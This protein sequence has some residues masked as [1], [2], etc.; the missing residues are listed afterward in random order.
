MERQEVLDLIKEIGTIEDDVERRG[1]LAELTDEVSKGY[2]S[3]ETLTAENETLIKDNERIRQQN[4]DLYL[5]VGEPKK[6]EGK[7]S[8]GF[9]DREKRKFED[10]FDEKGGIK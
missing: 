3:I 9:E 5:R 6:E 10:L 8:E 2:E 7:G 4:M 1:K